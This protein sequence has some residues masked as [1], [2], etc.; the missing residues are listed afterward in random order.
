MSTTH[1]LL[2]EGGSPVR[3]LDFQESHSPVGVPLTEEEEMERHLR[4][5]E[6]QLQEEIRQMELAAAAT[7]QQNAE[8]VG[9]EPVGMVSQNDKEEPLSLHGEHN[10]GPEFRHLLLRMSP[11]HAQQKSS[12]SACTGSGACG[13]H[14]LRLYG[15]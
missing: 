2:E 1:T 13:L 4:E 7:M 15:I 10:R 6:E 12:T 3:L 14:G 9:Q 11:R 5:M 8:A